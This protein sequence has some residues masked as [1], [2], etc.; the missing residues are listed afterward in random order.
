MEMLYP[1]EKF[2]SSTVVVIREHVNDRTCFDAP[3]T[4]RAVKQLEINLVKF[5]KGKKKIKKNPL[6]YS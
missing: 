4:T 2:F 1:K 6:P 5:V 3:S